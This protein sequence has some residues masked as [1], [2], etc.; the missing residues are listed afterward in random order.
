MFQ[1]ENPLKTQT[2]AGNPN[3]AVEEHF[4][5]IQLIQ[6][7]NYAPNWPRF[8][9]FTSSSHLIQIDLHG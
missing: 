8:F 2:T 5:I 4:N 6:Q 7:A 3:I 1:E 9:F